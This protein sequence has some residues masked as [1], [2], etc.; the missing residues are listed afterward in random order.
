[1]LLH[2]GGEH[3]GHEI[4]RAHGRGEG[5]GRTHRIALVRQRGR[6]A[7]TRR[8][9]LEDLADLRL[10]EQREVA[11]ELAE[12]GDE[13]AEHGGNLAQAVA[14]RVPWNVGGGQIEFPR[15]RGGDLGSMAAERGERAGRT[16][17]LQHEVALANVLQTSAVARHAIE[18]PRELQSQ[19][20][21]QC[22]L[23]PRATGHQRGTV[24]RYL[25]AQRRAQAR[26]V[27]VDEVQCI[28]QLQ[29]HG[30][31]LHVLARG[32]PVDIALGGGIR[33]RHA[34]GERGHEWNREI[35]GAPCGMAHGTQVERSLAAARLDHAR[36]GGRDDARGGLRTRQ[37]CLEVEHARNEG[38]VGE[39]PAHGI[40]REERVG[41]GGAASAAGEGR[42]D[43]NSSV[44]RGSGAGKRRAAMLPTAGS[45][46][47][48]CSCAADRRPS[49]YRGRRAGW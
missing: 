24:R 1:M 38:M 49:A 43:W 47:A 29:H 5:D 14:L 17:E 32:A 40:G 30:G 6:S 41:H 26:D 2:R 11:R 44:T 19:R 39:D 8:R 16:S 23:Q 18:H 4:G 15:E 42:K 28:A 37:G 21:G 22:L 27:R 3:R 36:C 9:R 46:G 13:H 20:H 48:R 7:A 25:P 31:V 35:A 10:R 34:A 45:R 33:C 12:R